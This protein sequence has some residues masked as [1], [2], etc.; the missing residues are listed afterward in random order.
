MYQLHKYAKV[1]II[2][3]KLHRLLVNVGNTVQWLR[4]A[5]SKGPNWVGVFRPKP[6]D[7]NRSGFRNVVFSSS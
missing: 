1:Y 4:L 6:E 2:S 5:L 7:G 3:Y